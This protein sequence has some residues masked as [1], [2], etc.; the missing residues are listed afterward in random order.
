MFQVSSAKASPVLCEGQGPSQGCSGSSARG[1]GSVLVCVSHMI[2]TSLLSFWGLLIEDR[3][4]RLP[5]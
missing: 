4:Q 2:T 1:K 5:I 3:A